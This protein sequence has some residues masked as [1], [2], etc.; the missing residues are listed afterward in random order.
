MPDLTKATMRICEVEGCHNK[1]YAKGICR[2]HYHRQLKYGRLHLAVRRD[3]MTRFDVKSNGCWIW[4][5]SKNIYGYGHLKFHGKYWLAHRL[6]YMRAKGAIPDGLVIDH[7]CRC[8]DCI[9]PDH[10]EPVTNKENLLRGLR[11]REYR[12]ARSS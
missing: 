10:M 3:P 6:S 4:S 8:R 5:G 1:Q 2:A 9:N 12:R 11:A 7:L